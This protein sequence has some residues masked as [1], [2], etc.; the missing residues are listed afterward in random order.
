M[1]G[2]LFFHVYYSQ[3]WSWFEYKFETGEKRNSVFIASFF[4]LVKLALLCKEL[5]LQLIKTCMELLEVDYFSPVV[6]YHI[7]ILQFAALLTVTVLTLAV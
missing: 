7:A 4:F 2:F 3:F 1:K 6:V 5:S